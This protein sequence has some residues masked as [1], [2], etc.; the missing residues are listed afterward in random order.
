[1]EKIV[2]EINGVGRVELDAS[3]QDL[4]PEKQQEIVNGIA[5]S[6]VSSAKA[7]PRERARAA[8]Q[9]A[10]FGFADE[11]VAA[12]A[13]PLSAV[14]A[15]FGGA[16]EDYYSR[17]ASE[18]E[19]L[20]AYQAASPIEAGLYEVGGAF[21]PGL[22]A[23]P[24]TGGSSAVATGAPLLTRAAQALPRLLGLGAAGGGLYGAGTA[25][26]GLQNRLTGA[27]GGAVMGAVTAPIAAAAT[28]PLQ[29]GAKAVA[30][31]ARARF[32][33]RAGKA[34]EA[35]LQRMADATGLTPDEIAARVAR[36]EIMAEN[37][38][39]R[40][41]TRA[42]MAQGGRPESMVRQTML[43]RPTRLRQE[44]MAE[45]QDYLAP[46]AD[47]NVKR[48]QQQLER[49]A[50]TAENE[51]YANIPGAK[52]PAARPVVDAV[53]AAVNQFPQAARELREFVGGSTRSRPFFEFDGDKISVGRLPTL[54]EAELVR[55]F[56]SKKANE[57][58]RSGS[59]MGEVYD[60][61]E[62][63]LRGALDTASSDLAGVRAGAA[64]LRQA[65]EAFDY[66]VAAFG[67]DPD[68]FE[69]F[70]AQVQ[71]NDAALKALRAGVAAALRRKAS[72]GGG[73]SLMG[74]LESE[75]RDYGQILRAVFPDQGL[76]DILSRVEVAAQ[77]QAARGDIIKG[78]STALVQQARQR[79]GSSV[80]L[81]E[82]ASAMRGNPLAMLQVGMKL[83]S[84]LSPGLTEQQRMKIVEVLLSEDPQVVLRALRDESGAAKFGAAVQSVISRLRGGLT[85]AAAL[86]AGAAGGQAATDLF[87]AR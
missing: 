3:F 71:D 66:G 21:V 46:G 53:A 56:L 60:T 23:A 82:A 62:K 35:E 28:V 57:A 5:A 38:T 47:P 43:E 24:F 85:G 36:G 49:A 37:E 78:P 52:D 17:L 9:G 87:G 22:L 20:A 79:L 80:N 83:A 34:V 55:R 64:T 51:A 31:A 61:F 42:L 4:P 33:N 75:N 77:S 50:R 63:E 70:L 30:D 65:K 27:G 69:I 1:M 2:I 25:E 16:G 74:R 18:R 40:M 10:T 15:A 76:D 39:L 86:S 84:E 72:S 12:A 32:G 81:E 8:A 68:E 45:I 19:R 73:T 14:S 59:P 7:A 48:V 26:G 67:K 6:T 29:A 13:N 58:Y 44:A 41:A 54:Q 11:I